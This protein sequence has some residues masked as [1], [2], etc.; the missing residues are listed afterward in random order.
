VYFHLGRP[1]RSVPPLRDARALAAFADTL[2]A[3]D[4]RVLAFAVPSPELVTDSTL[5]RQPGLRV[6]ERL[7]DGLV[8]AAAP[9]PVPAVAPRRGEP[10]D[11]AASIT[12]MSRAARAVHVHSRLP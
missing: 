12:R 1:S 5:Q 9:S 7:R 2:R 10:F 11:S 6:V 3:R 8:L 4:G